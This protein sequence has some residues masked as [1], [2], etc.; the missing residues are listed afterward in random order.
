MS[1]SMIVCACVRRYLLYIYIYIIYATP[2]LF[3]HKHYIII[4]NISVFISEV[5]ICSPVL[6]CPRYDS[7]ACASTRDVENARPQE[8]ALG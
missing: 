2:H 7:V 8:R 5:S 3:L 4:L 1:E 6:F